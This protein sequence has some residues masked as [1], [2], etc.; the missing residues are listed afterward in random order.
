MLTLIHVEIHYNLALWS[1]RYYKDFVLLI[2]LMA[3]PASY[4]LL[5]LQ[6]QSYILSQLKANPHTT[7]SG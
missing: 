3:V 6:L 1:S 5:L 2:I 7:K 4:D